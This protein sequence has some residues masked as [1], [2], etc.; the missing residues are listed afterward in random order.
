MHVERHLEVIESKGTRKAKTQCRFR[1]IE[2]KSGMSRILSASIPAAID[3]S[4]LDEFDEKSDPLGANRISELGAT[5]VAAPVGNAVFDAVGIR[6]R[7][8]PIT[9]SKVVYVSKSIALG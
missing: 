6:V 9:P 7:D 2:G 5:G 8:L 4:F 3:V 1:E